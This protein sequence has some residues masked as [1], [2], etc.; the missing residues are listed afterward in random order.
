MSPPD[1][2][3]R[4]ARAA[5][6]GRRSHT[7][8]Y[9][10]DQLNLSL[11]ERLDSVQ[12]KFERVLL[13]GANAALVEALRA[14]GL[15]VRVT[16]PSPQRA[17]TLGGEA[18]DEDR[19]WSDAPA[20][21]LILAGGTLD[22]VADLPGA[23]ILARRALVPDGLFL[24]AM[25]G[26]PSL[27]ALRAAAHQADEAEGHSAGRFHPLVDAR[28]AGDLLVRAG[29]AL[30]VADAETITLSYRDVTALVADLRAAAATNVLAARYPVTRGWLQTLAHAFAANGNGGR[31]IERLTI[32]AM[33]GWAPADTQPR[34]AARGSGLSLTRV[35]PSSG[36]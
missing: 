3:S 4:S 2:F 24:A 21:D 11:L 17:L 20:F 8:A 35:L 23:L 26:H 29:F 9:L 34:P 25:F 5:R 19:P 22:T 33:T 1:L 32:I 30:P 16:D 36:Q 10:E 31:T 6:R 12:R 15:D 13:I 14:R 27:P 28:S 18:H 7:P